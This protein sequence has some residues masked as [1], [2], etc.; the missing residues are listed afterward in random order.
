M[1]GTGLKKC[2]PTTLSGRPVAAASGVIEMLDVFVARMTCGAHSVSSC[3]KT[4]GLEGLVFRHG[5]D[6][7]FGRRCRR[8]IAFETDAVEDLVGT[9]C[10]MILPRLIPFSTEA[11]MWA[12]AACRC[13]GVHLDDACLDPT[14]RRRFRQSPRPI[15]PAP[16]TASRFTVMDFL[17]EPADIPQP[18]SAIPQ[19]G[20]RPTSRV[21]DRNFVE[22]RQHA[23]EDEVFEIEVVPGVH[24]QVRARAPSSP[25]GRISR[26]SFRRPS[27]PFRKRGRMARYKA[28][29][30]RHSYGRPIPP[31][32]SSGSTNRLTRTPACFSLPT[33]RR[34]S[35][36]EV[37]RRPPRLAGDFPGMYRHQRALVRTDFDDK[38]Q[39]FR[40]WVPFDVE[41]DALSQRM[42]F[43]GE[44]ADVSGV[45]CRRSARGWTVIPGA[46][47]AR[48]VR[49][50]SIT[51]GMLTAARIPKGGDF[52]NVDAQPHHAWLPPDRPRAYLKSH[53][54]QGED[55]L[56]VNAF[57]E[58]AAQDSNL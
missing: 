55:R 52:I 24:S 5:F 4:L 46:P 25:P 31:A 3:R 35:S 8:Q 15:V 32:S 38:L 13:C 37:S 29:H 21:A 22:V 36:A 30:G 49:T 7:E 45:M 14:G 9:G 47:A 56:W 17:P 18:P 50:A 1:I 28:R 48:H 6:D 42:Q 11:R 23:K 54:R 43:G 2:M 16:M 57:K 44:F 41:F 20:A 10:T 12:A 34:I 53:R 19:T 26:S 39:E 58:W 27:L 40:P 51:L 33:I